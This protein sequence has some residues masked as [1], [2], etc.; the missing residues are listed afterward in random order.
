MKP[1]IKASVTTCVICGA[2]L[3]VWRPLDGVLCRSLTCAARH[4][5]LAPAGR[6]AEC[7]RPLTASQRARGYCDSQSCRAEVLRVRREAAAA[8]RA[9]LLAKIEA[10]RTRAAARRGIARDDAATY[11]A[12]LLPRNDDRVSK[13]SRRRRADHEAHLRQSLA[14]ARAQRAASRRPPVMDVPAEVITP[15]ATERA[16]ARL[17]L[18]G[19]AAC[20]GR[21]CRQGGD[22]AFICEDTMLAQLQRDPSAGDETIIQRYLQHL[23]DRTMT[24]GC[25]YQGEHGCTLA[26]E[27]RADICHRF[28]CTG[29]L[30]LP[31]QVGPDQPVRAYLIHR[32]GERLTG[33]RFV[34]IDV[35]RQDA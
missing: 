19:C 31:G 32:R 11:R 12:A 20:R 7:T 3:P 25:V 15:T 22:H 5:A 9:S 1:A 17:L 28:L 29:L 2:S 8:D 30:M 24:H 34:E 27:L 10:R 18:A 23:G 26:P 21:C 14:G 4:R 16:H 13:L 35:V 33:D 6:C